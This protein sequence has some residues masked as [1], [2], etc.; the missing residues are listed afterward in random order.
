MS[1]TT[2][3]QSSGNFETSSGYIFVIVIASIP[4]TKDTFHIITGLS[5]AVMTSARCLVL[6]L[7]LLVSMHRPQC[8]GTRPNSYCE[9]A[10]LCWSLFWII[11]QTGLCPPYRCRLLAIPGVRCFIGSNLRFLPLLLLSSHESTERNRSPRCNTN[12]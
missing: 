2:R 6:Q 4:E 8:T 11:N 5:M 3:H 7:L 10:L 9:L 1:H 12:W